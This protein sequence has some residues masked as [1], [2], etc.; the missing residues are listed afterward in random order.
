M[1]NVCDLIE[2]FNKCFEKEY[3][4]T[5]LAGDGEPIYIPKNSSDDKNVIYF[6]NGFFS[7][8]LHECAHWFIAGEKRRTLVDYG[9]W[10]IPDGRNSEQQAEFFKVEV[11]P[12]ALEWIFSEA[13]GYKFQFS[14]DNLSG[15]NFDVADFKE[16]VKKQVL[17]YKKGGLPMRANIFLSSLLRHYELLK[18]TKPALSDSF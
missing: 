6:A 5:L 16:S 10:Y 2:I 1:Y 14:V 3:N 17:T 11:K 18:V 9:Y 13:I 4:T 12:Q 7:S 8:A 15:E